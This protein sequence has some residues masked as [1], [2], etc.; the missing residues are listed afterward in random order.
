[1]QHMMHPIF[2]LE[3]L[4]TLTHPTRANI[5]EMIAKEQVT[6]NDIMS[7]TSLSRDALSKHLRKLQHYSLVKADVTKPK[8]DKYVFY[9]L[10]KHGK[11]FHILLHDIISKLSKISPPKISEN[12][13]LDYMVL[14]SIINTSGIDHLYKIFSQCMIVLTST[15]YIRLLDYADKTNN[16]K[17][18]K[19]L[20]NEKIVKVIEIYENPEKGVAC[21]FYLRRAKKLL[22]EHAQ[23]IASAVDSNSSIISD[24]KKILLAAKSLGIICTSVDTILDFNSKESLRD[25]FYKLSFGLEDL[26]NLEY[27]TKHYSRV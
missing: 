23:F 20:N 3:I 8:A 19:L 7:N 27:I 11:K 4:N 10:T 1:M 2:N 5:F 18:E 13:L 17:L 21:E 25:E 6:F 24:N 9:K 15:D 26:S 14:K 16:E 22:P 12:F